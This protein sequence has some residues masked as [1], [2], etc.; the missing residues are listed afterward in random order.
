MARKKWSRRSRRDTFCAF[1]FIAVLWGTTDIKKPVTD[2]KTSVKHEVLSKPVPECRHTGAQRSFDPSLVA[3][4]PSIGNRSVNYR[5]IADG[6]IYFF[7][8]ISQ[9]VASAT[10]NTHRIIGRA[11]SAATTVALAAAGGR[12]SGPSI[13]RIY[14]S[15]RRSEDQLVVATS[16]ESVD[17]ARQSFMVRVSTG[18]N[19]TCTTSYVRT[20]ACARMSVATAYHGRQRALTVFLRRFVSIVRRPGNENITLVIGTP[21]KESRYVSRVI[22]SLGMSRSARVVQTGTDSVG[23]FSR[24]VSLR[25]AISTLKPDELVAI[26]DVDLRI[27]HGF[28]RSCRENTVRGSQVWF[29]VMFVAYPNGTRVAAGEGS[30]SLWSYGTASFFKSDYDAVGGFGEGLETKYLGWGPEDKDFFLR[31]GNHHPG[32]ALFRSYSP[33]LFHVWHRKECERNKFHYN[34]VRAIVD[35]SGKKRG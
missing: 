4:R 35:Q 9:T 18:E 6:T 33:D 29:P 27:S 1:V 14:W 24:S 5:T 16:V 10:V 8:S 26:V 3:E 22:A 28:L 21:G 11:V 31:F 34:C 23:N 12:G 13:G 17:G 25:D 15:H 2:V 32:Y 20:N 7:P 30:W 19:G